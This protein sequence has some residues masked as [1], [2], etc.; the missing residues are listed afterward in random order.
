MI[1]PKIRKTLIL[2]H[3]YFAAFMAPAFLLVALS[4]G[5]YLLGNKGSIQSESLQLPVGAVLNF[6]SETLESDIQA[7]LVSA[8]I[9]HK[10]EYLKTSGQ[11]ATTR[12]TS[13]T[14]IEI[15]QSDEGLQATVNKPDLQYA[16]MELHKGHGPKLFKLYQMLV[17]LALLGVVLGGLTVGLLAK[18]FRRKTF[19]TA[20]IGLIVFL[21][22]SLFA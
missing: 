7:L 2:V 17:A 20:M 9:D 6:Q 13:R 22:L 11:K 10:F 16:M 19:I 14:H 12:P 15:T 21:A 4:G 3:M 5:L 18:S 8:G 1:N